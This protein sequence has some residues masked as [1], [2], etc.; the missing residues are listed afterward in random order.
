MILVSAVAQSGG[1]FEMAKSRCNRV[2]GDFGSGSVIKYQKTRSAARTPHRASFLSSVG[3]AALMTAASFAP[4]SS[5]VPS[6][7][8]PHLQYLVSDYTTDVEVK[9]VSTSK[10]Q[11]VRAHL[12]VTPPPVVGGPIINPLTGAVLNILEI[13]THGVLATGNV[14]ILT[15]VTV[16][17]ILPSPEVTTALP[18]PTVEIASVVLSPTT[19]LPISVVFVDGRTADVVTPVVLAPMGTSTDVNLSVGINDLNNQ[20]D[21]RARPGAAGGR[22]GALFV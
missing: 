14:L 22:A 1:V 7:S 13:Y 9:P 11:T 15:S 3:A 18:D 10:M 8:L 2:N 16:G 21:I 17:D 6:D 20:A 19:H 12:P 5:P 4:N